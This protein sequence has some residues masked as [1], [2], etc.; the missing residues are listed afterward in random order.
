MSLHK[1]GGVCA[2]LSATD[3]HVLMALLQEDLHGYAIMK[4]VDKDSGG[5]VSAE[6]GSLYRIL[7]RMMTDGLVDEV[8]AP[9]NAPTETRGRPRRY[10]RL[11][12]DGR[13][14]LRQ[15]SMR[16]R[17]ALALANERQLLPESAK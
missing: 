12:P 17:D 8:D 15:E 11:T 5:G 10:Y 9:Q 14:A 16:L 6:I 7:S 13:S 3:W 4:A 1:D 2:P